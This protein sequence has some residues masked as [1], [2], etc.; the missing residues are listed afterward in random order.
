LPF[1]TNFWGE[2]FALCDSK[3][4][5]FKMIEEVEV[6]GLEAIK[7]THPNGDSVLIYKLGNFRN[8]VDPNTAQKELR[9]F[10]ML[11]KEMKPYLYQLRRS[12]RMARRSGKMFL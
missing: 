9:S 12:F 10:L 4:A 7:L 1:R 11:L 6:N 2:E 8:T 3:F 5:I